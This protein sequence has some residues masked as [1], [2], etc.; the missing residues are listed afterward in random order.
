LVAAV[1]AAL[2]A[3]AASVA[4]A[5]DVKRCG[6]TI[7]AGSTG[8]LVQH[9]EC[10]WRCVANPTRRCTSD[11]D[12]HE[13]PVAGDSCAPEGIVLERDATLDLNGFSLRGVPGRD[14]IRCSDARTGR[15]IVEG[16]GALVAVGGRAMVGGH[17][18]VVLR[19]LTV[20]GADASIETTGRVRMTGV[21]LS[22]CGG[23]PGLI[24]GVFGARGVRAIEVYLDS[25][26]YVRSGADLRVAGGR[27]GR[28]YVAP[29][30]GPSFVA[31]GDVRA[32]GVLVRDGGFAGRNVFLKSVRRVGRPTSASLPDAVARK[33]LA[34]RDSTL[35][36]VESGRAPRLV[37]ATCVA[38][39]DGATGA[40][41]GVCDPE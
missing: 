35:G 37:N 13:C 9:V 15:C 6:V 39:R 14:L 33:R 16:P 38:S 30:P 19:D 24:G 8:T 29:F 22:A 23:T 28:Q 31:A 18:T 25:G 34:L 36:V 12:A 20:F 2:I 41:W 17:Q 32:S 1:A 26:C 10:G 21:A 4:V 11:G 40:S 27:S 7:A 5:R 3:G